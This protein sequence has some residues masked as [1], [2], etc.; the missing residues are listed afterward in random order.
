MKAL[1]QSKFN[2]HARATRKQGEGMFVAFTYPS[3]VCIGSPVTSQDSHNMRFCQI[4]F[5]ILA[6]KKR[7]KSSLFLD[8]SYNLDVE[9]DCNAEMTSQYKGRDEIKTFENKNGDRSL[10][11]NI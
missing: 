6:G 1:L 2:A 10:W 9:N 4:I 7:E 11:N 3:I 8:T 5:Q